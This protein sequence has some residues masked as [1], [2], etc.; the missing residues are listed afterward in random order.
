[1]YL[2]PYAPLLSTNLF[3]NIKHDCISDINTLVHDKLF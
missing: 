2:Y 3:P 1:M